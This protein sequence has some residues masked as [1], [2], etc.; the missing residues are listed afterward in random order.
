MR[1]A[2][3]PHNKSFLIQQ[4]SGLFNHFDY[5]DLQEDYTKYL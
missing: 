3:I 4:R 1:L 2:S 5:Q